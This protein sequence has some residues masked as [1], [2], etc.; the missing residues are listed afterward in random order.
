MVVALTRSKTMHAHVH[1]HYRVIVYKKGPSIDRYGDVI[2]TVALRQLDLW[3]LPVGMG[4]CGYL[5]GC[6]A[7]VVLIRLPAVALVS[8]CL[9]TTL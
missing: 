7:K 2:V 3:W 9:L 8:L 6:V 4:T 1:S 5:W